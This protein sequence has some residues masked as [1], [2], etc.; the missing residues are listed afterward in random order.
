MRIID[1]TQF[2]KKLKATIQKTGRMGFTSE[3]VEAL[4]LDDNTYAKFAQDD[5]RADVLYLIILRGEDANAFKVVKSGEYFYVPTKLMFDAMGYDYRSG[6]ISFDLARMSNLDEE[7]GGEVY[8]MTKKEHT[9]T[10]KKQ[11]TEQ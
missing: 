11:V 1:I 10:S 9:R 6:F 3:T 4:K 2:N 7:A 8:K 5:D